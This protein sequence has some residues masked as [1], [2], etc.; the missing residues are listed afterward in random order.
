MTLSDCV[1]QHDAHW[2]L[3]LE[4][5]DI[6]EMFF[7]AHKDHVVLPHPKIQDHFQSFREICPHNTLKPKQHFLLHYPYYTRLLGPL[8]QCWC[9][10]L[11][12]NITVSAILCTF[13]EQLHQCMPYTV[14]DTSLPAGL[15][16]VTQIKPLHQCPFVKTDGVAYYQKMY[17]VVKMCN[18]D[19]IFG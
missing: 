14:N 12:Q 5:K 8:Q 13:C 9:V 16:R 18:N 19:P 1:T 3:P 7:F 2:R 4:Q 6:T 17:V 11:R 10:R 15:L